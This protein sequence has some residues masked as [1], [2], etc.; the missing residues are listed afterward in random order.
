MTKTR[1]TNGGAMQRIA[2]DGVGTN[3]TRVGSSLATFAHCDPAYD[4]AARML[5]EAAERRDMRR[6]KQPVTIRKFSWEKDQ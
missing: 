3:T 2:R 6:T 1:G 4:I 5:Q